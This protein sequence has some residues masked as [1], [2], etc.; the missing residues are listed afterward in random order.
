[1]FTIRKQFDTTEFK[2]AVE[3]KGISIKNLAKLCGVSIKTIYNAAAGK[4][5]NIE[6]YSRIAKELFVSKVSNVSKP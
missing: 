5:L 4:R 2:K 6:T 3:V 1:M